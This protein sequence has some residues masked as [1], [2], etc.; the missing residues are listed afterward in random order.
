MSLEKVLEILLQVQVEAEAPAVVF[1]RNRLQHLLTTNTTCLSVLLFQNKNNVTR[2]CIRMLVSHLS[3]DNLAVCQGDLFRKGTKKSFS[4]IVW[5]KWS[6]Q[7]KTY[8]Q[9]HIILLWICVLGQKR[10]MLSRVN[11]FPSKLATLCPSGAP[12][13]MC[14]SRTFRQRALKAIAKRPKNPNHFWVYNIPTPSCAPPLFPAWSGSSFPGHRSYG[15]ATA[16]ALPTSAE[17]SWLELSE[18]SPGPWWKKIDDCDW[19]KKMPWICKKL[20]GQGTSAGSWASDSSLVRP[21]TRTP[22]LAYR[23]VSHVTLSSGSEH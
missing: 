8:I 10:W 9:S 2:I 22:L 18:S 21:T 14:T 11:V 3:K 7:P 19:K 16:S 20:E 23:L 4:K 17:C 12:F 5:P 6:S 13:W 15:I 1:R